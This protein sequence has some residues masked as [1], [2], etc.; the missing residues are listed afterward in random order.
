MV[1]KHKRGEVLLMQSQWRTVGHAEV[2]ARWGERK[3]TYKNISDM[4][5]TNLALSI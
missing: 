1:R 5:K 3:L 2:D 4:T